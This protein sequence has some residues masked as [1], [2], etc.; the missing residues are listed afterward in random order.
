MKRTGLDR[1]F[2]IREVNALR[3]QGLSLADACETVGVPK[4]TYCDWL[5]RSPEVSPDLLEDAPRSGRPAFEF[6]EAAVEYVR[7]IYLRSNLKRGAGSMTFAWRYAAKDKGSPLSQAERDVV[8]SPRAQKRALPRACFRALKAIPRAAVRRY[9][10]PQSGLNDGIYSSGWLRMQEDGSRRLL[11]GERQ[12]WDDASVNVGVCVPWTRGGDPCS[13]KY[14]VRV[15]RFQL[16]AGIDCAT[17]FC[18]GTAYVMR[19]S[20]GYRAEDVVRA[21]DCAWAM[22]GFMPKEMVLE[23][24]SWQAQRTLDFL[25]DAGIKTISAKGRPNQKLVEGW[26]N[27]LWTVMSVVLPPSGQVGRFRGEMARENLLW[28]QCREGRR[29]P[30]EIFPDLKTFLSAL[31]TSVRYLNDESI[32]SKEYGSWVPGEKFAGAKENGL[33]YS[34]WLR[35]LARPVVEV[36]KLRRD[37]IV[38]VSAESP[39]GWSHNYLFAVNDGWR[40]DGASVRVSFDPWRIRDGAVVELL[41][42]HGRSSV[43]DVAAG[44]VSPAPDPESSRG[45]CDFRAG[46]RDAKK[47]GRA[48]VATQIAAY[49]ERGVRSRRAVADNGAKPELAIRGA[50]PP[51][52]RELS[53]TEAKSLDDAY[54]AELIELSKLENEIIFA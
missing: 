49:D 24:G 20:D 4:R 53:A 11:P 37:G 43:I 48:A 22:Q 25:K 39:F 31:D 41:D 32:E 28:A 29:D 47:T 16:L 5:S 42:A 10:D 12:V 36:R 35:R 51:L 6:S 27:R 19:P 3:E 52:P 17:D 26:F 40:Y 18:V 2:I 13:E 9:R 14:G 8:L 7:R 1:V 46:A 34:D 38:A 44:C 15:A 23:G 33:V 50:I 30:R 45:W 21:W 54:E